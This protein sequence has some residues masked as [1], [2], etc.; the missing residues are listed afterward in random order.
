MRNRI[1]LI[2][3]IL[4]ASSVL[5]AT[6]I[7]IPADYS[8]IQEGIDA[9]VDGDSILVAPGDY[10][11]FLT[12][13]GKA[14]TLSSTDGPKNTSVRNIDISDV[15][16]GKVEVSGLRI[17]KDILTWGSALDISNSSDVNISSNIFPSFVYLD[18]ANGAVYLSSAIIIDNSMA[19][20]NRNIF[21]NTYD[22]TF[23]LDPGTAA[24]QINSNSDNTSII[25][26]TFYNNGQGVST[27]SDN[28]T[29]LNNIFDHMTI[30]AVRLDSNVTNVQANYNNYWNNYDNYNNVI[31]SGGND[32]QLDPELFDTQ[33]SI[34]YILSTSPCRNTGDP[35]AVYNDPDGSRNDIGAL[36]FGPQAPSS[37][38]NIFPSDIYNTWF[39]INRYPT[40][41]WSPS[42]DPNAGD[43]IHYQLWTASALPDGTKS[44]TI[45]Y[46]NITDTSF[47]FTDPLANG[48]KFYLFVRA[49]DNTGMYG[50][51]N[52]GQYD[53]YLAWRRGDVNLSGTV[54]IADIVYLVDYMF[55]DGA[56]VNPPRV[57]DFDGNCTIDISDLILLVNYEFNG[58]P[59]SEIQYGC[60]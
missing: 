50:T 9:A 20:I 5:H 25:N 31:V 19:T 7:H 3:V 34:F 29:I 1:F 58:L 24:V 18:D 10:Y 14:I 16:S 44:A 23:L 48:E 22:S 42:T 12:I 8:T 54:E 55:N 15:L 36:P 39:V 53:F 17:L 37:P 45:L 60:D 35:D 32:L 26:N 46:D 57:G 56:A 13:T 52:P 27:S 2:V 40:I 4:L 41:T 38:Q 51:N 11:E 30:L 21:N 28:V 59:Y 6:T 47:T 33:N 49:V 43:S